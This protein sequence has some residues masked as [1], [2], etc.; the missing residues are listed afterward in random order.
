MEIPVQR[1]LHGLR[2]P[3]FICCRIDSSAPVFVGSNSRNNPKHDI[4]SQILN[5][6]LG[7]VYQSDRWALATLSKNPPATT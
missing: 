4:R 7:S 1:H 2:R 5:D 6:I 3:A